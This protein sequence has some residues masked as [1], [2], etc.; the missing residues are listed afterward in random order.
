MFKKRWEELHDPK[1]EGMSLKARLESGQKGKE[2]A[3]AYIPSFSSSSPCLR[4]KID[5]SKL[6]DEIGNIKNIIGLEPCTLTPSHGD[7]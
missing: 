2:S 3:N 7:V 6:A 1:V 4:M 5:G